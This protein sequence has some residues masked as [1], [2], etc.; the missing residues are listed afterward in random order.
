MDKY[1]LAEIS[2]KSEASGKDGTDEWE[3]KLIESNDIKSVAKLTFESESSNTIENKSEIKN[4]KK[5][6]Q[7]NKNAKNLNIDPSKIKILT[8]VIGHGKSNEFKTVN[9]VIY[10]NNYISIT[11]N[12]G[13]SS[14]YESGNYQYIGNVNG[15]NEYKTAIISLNTNIKNNIDIWKITLE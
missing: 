14:N 6:V 5:I 15:I 12:T 10:I 13:L 3:V 8:S 7:L 2:W 4:I 11:F 1:K 9:Y